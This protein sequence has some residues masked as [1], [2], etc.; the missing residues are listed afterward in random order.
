MSLQGDPLIGLT[1]N[2]DESITSTV[3]FNGLFSSFILVVAVV[4]LDSFVLLG[5]KYEKSHCTCGR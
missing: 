1:K 4:H 2:V 3:P 5:L